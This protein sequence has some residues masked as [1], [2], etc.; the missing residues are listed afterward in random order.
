[1]AITRRIKITR[2]L[3]DNDRKNDLYNDVLCRSPRRRSHRFRSL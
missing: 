1:M 2:S 3:C